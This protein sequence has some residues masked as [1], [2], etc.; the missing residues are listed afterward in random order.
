MNEQ[1]K[2]RKPTRIPALVIATALGLS[3]TSYAENYDVTVATDNGTGDT[4]STLS[5]AIRQTNVNPDAD[6]I[7]LKTN[8]TITG[9][10]KTLIDGAPSGGDHNSGG[11]DLFQIGRAH[12]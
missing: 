10:M 8:V 3:T 9:V 11:G 6:T 1:K 4:A 12:V 7:T 2:N 5:W